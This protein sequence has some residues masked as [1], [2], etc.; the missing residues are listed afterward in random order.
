MVTFDTNIWVR[1]LTNDDE[2]QARREGFGGVVA[3]EGRFWISR[4][5]GIYW[6]FIGKT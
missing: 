3:Y 1:Y 2:L 4:Y 5:P 6:E